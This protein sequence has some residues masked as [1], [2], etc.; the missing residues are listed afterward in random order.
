MNTNTMPKK[1]ARKVQ[2]KEDN[3]ALNQ[4][5]ISK[6]TANAFI[7]GAKAE[8]SNI[9]P[10]IIKKDAISILRSFANAND[11]DQAKK[12]ANDLFNVLHISD[13]VYSND[14][15]IRSLFKNAP[16]FNILFTDAD[17]F[18]NAFGCVLKKYIYN[19]NSREQ[20]I[21][22]SMMDASYFCSYKNSA[23][24]IK[25]INNYLSDFELSTLNE[26]NTFDNIALCCIRLEEKMN[27]DNDDNLNIG[28]MRQ[29]S[30]LL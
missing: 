5:R 16:V 30:L 25:H 6:I 26:A 4:N 14:L 15:G 11:I 23:D 12:I 7:K 1:S 13:S 29:L 27:K 10:F 9:E 28:G 8:I 22:Y 3:N 2:V 18:N 17:K 20:V 19:S 21:L 24:V